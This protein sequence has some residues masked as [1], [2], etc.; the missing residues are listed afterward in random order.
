MG[1]LAAQIEGYANTPGPQTR[2]A[3]RRVR[4]REVSRIDSIEWSLRSHSVA[5]TLSVANIRALQ[6]LVRDRT[7]RRAFA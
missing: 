3:R 5:G 2:E 7:V 4:Q 1:T 6:R